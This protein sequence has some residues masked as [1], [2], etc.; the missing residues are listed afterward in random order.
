MSRDE[1]NPQMDQLKQYAVD[2][3]VVIR[4]DPH[5]SGFLILIDDEA[6]QS[7]DQ[8][9]AQYIEHVMGLKLCENIEATLSGWR[10]LGLIVNGPTT[11]NHQ[12]VFG[13]LTWRPESARQN[14]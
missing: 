5:M 10:Q 6:A 8:M 12:E 11:M 4:L 7:F 9:I 3:G 1:G 14:I 2:M 13:E